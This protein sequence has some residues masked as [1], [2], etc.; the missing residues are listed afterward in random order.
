M[1]TIEASPDRESYAVGENLNLSCVINPQPVFI[2]WIPPGGREII[3]NSRVI[4]HPTNSDDSNYNSILQFT[5]LMEGD[6]GN[7]TCNWRISEETSGSQSFVLQL[8]TSK[9]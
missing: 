6:E 8:L 7:Y 9:S 1:V 4:I 2:N 3:D 5:Y